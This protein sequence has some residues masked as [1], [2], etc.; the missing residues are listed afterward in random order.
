[1]KSRKPAQG[2]RH[3][4]KWGNPAKTC[5]S[6]RSLRRRL[7]EGRRGTGVRAGADQTP[8]SSSWNLISPT[9]GSK[10]NTT[11]KHDCDKFRWI[12]S[13]FLKC[14]YNGVCFVFYS[15]ACLPHGSDHLLP[16]VSPQQVTPASNC[17]SS[18]CR[19]TV[20]LFLPVPVFSSV[21][22]V[23]LSYCLAFFYSAFALWLYTRQVWKAIA[24][25]DQIN[26]WIWVLHLS[27][28]CLVV[29]VASYK[30]TKKGTHYSI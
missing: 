26:R 1:M 24:V 22:S 25:N 8:F 29:L 11:A 13:K 9:E 16:V 17:L 3:S 14:Y 10:T 4:V 15:K 12:W 27:S 2:K 20:C 28:K 18:M 6:C 19:K 30:S 21:I 23:P 7:D 5:C